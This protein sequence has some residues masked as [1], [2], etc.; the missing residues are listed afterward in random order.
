MQNSHIRTIYGS[1]HLSN[2]KSTKQEQKAYNAHDVQKWIKHNLRLI[3]KHQH[4]NL[5]SLID[6]KKTKFNKSLK[7]NNNWNYEDPQTFKNWINSLVDP[8]LI[9]NY[10]EGKKKSRR[11]KDF[12]EYSTKDKTKSLADQIIVS[13]GDEESFKEIKEWFTTS[14]NGKQFWYDYQ[15][16]FLRWL[17]KEVPTFKIYNSTLHLDE[18]TPHIHIVGVTLKTRKNYKSGIPIHIKNSAFVDTPEELK[19]IHNKFRKFNQEQV[20]KLNWILKKEFT[21]AITFQVAQ[22]KKYEAVQ[23]RFD[24]LE[25]KELIKK[26]EQIDNPKIKKDLQVLKK[27]LEERLDSGI[28][29]SQ[30]KRLKLQV[31]LLNELINSITNNL[32][33]NIN[34]IMWAKNIQ[35]LQKEI[36]QDPESHYEKYFGSEIQNSPNEVQ[37]ENKVSEIKKTNSGR[38]F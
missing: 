24:N 33:Q 11:V 26:I 16:D 35:I 6:F 1:F 10:N 22:E 13:L 4:K 30:E 12:Y 9:K 5:K 18:T 34:E 2:N 37:Q 7:V 14:I 25:L 23:K 29:G 28:S 15:K 31:K 27:Y 21:Q 38:S 36:I 8:Q 32:N 17:H 20:Q 3:E 19:E